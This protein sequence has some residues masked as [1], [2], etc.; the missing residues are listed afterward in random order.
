[1][2]RVVTR[3]PFV[4]LPDYLAAG[5]SLVF[6]GINP[7]TYSV[8]RGRYFARTTNRFWPA[9]SRSTLSAPIRIA[10]RVDTLGPEHDA[11][12]LEFG[13]GFTDVVKKPS[14]NAAGLTPRDFEL[15]AP[16]L[17]TRLRR[18][19]PRVA[20]FHGVTAY[21]PFARIVLGVDEG[22]ALGAQPATIGATQLFV[23]PNPSPANAHFTVADQAEWYDRLAAVL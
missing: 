5:L 23:V 17:A 16:R 3:Y 4:T 22:P 14:A 18:L 7:G 12:L 19:Q 6:V 20:C 11:T 15:W 13:I 2:R 10:L 1:M 8:A 21:R 9:F